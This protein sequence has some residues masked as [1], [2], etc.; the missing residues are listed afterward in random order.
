MG[1][2]KGFK[3]VKATRE[4]NIAVE[5]G[6][7]QKAYDVLYENRGDSKLMLTAIGKLES[8]HLG[9]EEVRII[10]RAIDF[11]GDDAARRG[12]DALKDSWSSL[13]TLAKRSYGRDGAAYAVMAIRERASAEA[14]AD[15]AAVFSERIIGPAEG[16]LMITRYDTCSENELREHRRKE[17]TAALTAIFRYAKEGIANK[18]ADALADLGEF[19]VLRE[20]AT[21]FVAEKDGDGKLA[22]V[23]DTIEHA[24]ILLAEQAD[25]KTLVA[26]VEDAR[27]G[28]VKQLAGTFARNRLTQQEMWRLWFFEPDANALLEKFGRIAEPSALAG[29]VHQMVEKTGRR[30]GY[31]DTKKRGAGCAGIKMILDG[32]EARSNGVGAEYNARKELQAAIKSIGLDTAGWK[33]NE[34]IGKSFKDT[35]EARTPY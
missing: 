34:K 27:D 13:L 20:T 17:A 4:F 12:V 8:G 2:V 29:F 25:T 3:H 31:D 14:V 26:C 1:I 7:F 15:A 28:R 24:V 18:A 11:G 19:D 10:F 22:P 16:A 6:N 5:G 33:A 32:L 23:P 30:A 35:A 21:R 9:T